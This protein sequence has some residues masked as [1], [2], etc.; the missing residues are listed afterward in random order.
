[1]GEVA[2]W[3][4]SCSG[5][6][7]EGALE[8]NIGDLAERQRQRRQARV[9]LCDAEVMCC[10]WCEILL[11]ASS[12]RELCGDVQTGMPGLGDRSQRCCS[13]RSGIALRVT[14]A[15]RKFCRRKLSWTRRCS[16]TCWS[17]SRSVGSPTSGPRN[18]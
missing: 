15:V 18:L 12:F 10:T 4:S 7:G 5:A 17:D 3:P 9:K 6:H 11:L 16:V 1:M 2:P 13:R 8:R 14:F